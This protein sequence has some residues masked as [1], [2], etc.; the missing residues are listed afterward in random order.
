L[1]SQ[2]W[3]SQCGTSE[4]R[5][6]LLLCIANLWR[7]AERTRESKYFS[8]RRFDMAQLISTE[9]LCP[10]W[11]HAKTLST[12]STT[13]LKRNNPWT[14]FLAYAR[15]ALPIYHLLKT[16]G[17]FMWELE[18][19]EEMETSSPARELREPINGPKNRQRRRNVDFQRSY[20]PFKLNPLNSKSKLTRRN[21]G[22]VADGTTKSWVLLN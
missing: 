16:I 7:Q 13:I 11:T 21:V 4:Q 20:W 3:I 5:L 2:V 10:R 15:R 17:T 8:I 19:C 14:G 9:Y 6:P 22:N 18:S 12:L 1:G